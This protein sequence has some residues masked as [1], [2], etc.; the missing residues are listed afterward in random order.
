MRN[1]AEK[2]RYGKILKQNKRVPLWVVAKTKR[3]VRF[4][5]KRHSWRHSKLK[6]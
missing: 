2:K 3:K 4:H 6:V 5:P 1:T